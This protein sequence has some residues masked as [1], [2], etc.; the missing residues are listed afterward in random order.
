M[1]R[2]LQSKIVLTFICTW[3]A[4]IIV[5]AGNNFTVPDEY[6]S[7]DGLLKLTLDLDWL[8]IDPGFKTESSQFGAFKTRAL[9]GSVPG[10]TVRVS[11][12]DTLEV[13][14]RNR[15]TRQDSALI[16][17]QAKNT[18]SFP[19][20]ANLHFHG[21]H[22][23]S[24]LPA[25]DTTLEIG[26]GEEYNYVVHFP[27]EHAPGTHWIHTHYHGSTTLHL[28]GGAA[29]CMIVK[30]P[31]GFLPAEVEEA[32]DVVMVLQ[33]WHFEQ[34]RT[35]AANAGDNKLVEQIEG[36]TG[37]HITINGHIEPTMN[38]KRGVWQ[39]W[40]ILHA[41]WYEL[42]AGIYLKSLENE[43]ECE[44]YLLAKDGIYVS[45]YPRSVR[46]LPIP[47]GGRADIM[48]RC[49][50]VGNSAVNAIGRTIIHVHV[51][52]DDS[53]IVSVE[54]G[55]MMDSPEPLTPWSPSKPLY[56]QDLRETEPTKDCTCGTYFEGYG[57]ES[58]INNMKYDKGN[59]FL[60]TSFLGAVVERNIAG[61]HEHAYH[62]HVHPYQLIGGFSESDY[63]KIGDWHDTW[64]DKKQ[65]EEFGYVIRYR[66]TN[67]PGKIMVHC[68]NSQHADEGM[69]AKEYV[70]NLTSAENGA[71]E[72]DVEGSIKGEGIVDKNII[73]ESDSPTVE[74]SSF[75]LCT[76]SRTALFIVILSLFS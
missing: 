40:R 59:H 36:F 11:A 64:Q 22:V 37:N 34:L 72:C 33:Y 42:D 16:S 65:G 21:G 61:V 9:G 47:P 69:L 45:D 17:S 66:L 70:F 29:L 44:F 35:S 5:N 43:A 19:D 55:Q 53:N 67:L 52:E 75:S 25:D 30:D 49:N 76:R 48:I 68:H 57:T 73:I 71:C 2:M 54:A 18:Y 51:I 4:V 3:S 38:V 23:S 1:I 56:L 14:F 24:V 39:R 46:S 62:Q 10:P 31:P 41:G 74:S 50:A 28:A 6:E 27:D 32:E 63:F 8:E 60:H 58:N 7:T 15:L 20:T 26:P 12:G 13:T